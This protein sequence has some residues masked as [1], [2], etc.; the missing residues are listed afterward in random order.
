MLKKNKLETA[1]TKV[2]NTGA[3]ENSIRKY[4]FVVWILHAIFVRFPRGIWNW[5]RGLDIVGMANAALL[6][7]IIVLFG[8]LIG[9]VLDV[10][11]HTNGSRTS[12]NAFASDNQVVVPVKPAQ[13]PATVPTE[14]VI[15]VPA[16]VT[17]D[18]AKDKLIVTLPLRQIARPIIQQAKTIDPA[19]TIEPAPKI[20]P[21]EPIA[22]KVVTQPQKPAKVTVRVRKV[23]IADTEPM[24]DVIVGGGTDGYRI[25]T[26]ANVRGNLF[27]QNMR[28]YTLPCDVRVDGDLYLRNVNMLRFCG[29][30]I[31][32]G[33]IYVSR[34]SSFGP[35]PR[36]ARLGG[37]V[38]F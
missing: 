29:P 38:I 15:D 6:V 16:R 14:T 33:N 30:F 32:T 31:V 4:G 5:I 8:M 24:G 35:I 26:G 17:I 10:T 34:N 25:T 2:A 27:L 22:K 7:L 13:K 12:K 9:Q 36:N 19:A 11:D 1:T 21:A 18:P 20:K 3:T 28:Y 37:Q 23:L